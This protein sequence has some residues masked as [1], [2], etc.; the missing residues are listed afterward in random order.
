MAKNKIMRALNAI[1]LILGVG[2]PGILIGMALWYRA[3]GP[4]WLAAALWAGYILGTLYYSFRSNHR[5][6]ATG[7]FMIVLA[8]TVMW[9]TSISAQNYKYW[10]P[11]VT[12]IASGD[13]NGSIATINHVRNFKWRTPD[14]YDVKW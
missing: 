2:L 6:L 7:L 12:H 9:W 4:G 13:I 8:G 3:P 14:D 10:K 1:G 5:P 11:E